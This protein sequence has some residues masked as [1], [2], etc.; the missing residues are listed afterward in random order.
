ML[1]KHKGVWS[2]AL[3]E[4]L[5]FRPSEMVSDAFSEY[6]ARIPRIMQTAHRGVYTRVAL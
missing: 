1:A 6:R 3:L 4:Q 2:H 5:E